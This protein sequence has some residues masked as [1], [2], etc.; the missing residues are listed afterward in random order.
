MKR[1]NSSLKLF[2]KDDSKNYCFQRNSELKNLDSGSRKDDKFNKSFSR[3]TLSSQQTISVKRR[4][5]ILKL[6]RNHKHKLQI[7]D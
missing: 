3:D 1:K 6:G 4:V 2:K 7:K 5:E